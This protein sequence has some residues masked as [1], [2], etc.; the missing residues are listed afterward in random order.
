MRDP[1]ARKAREM[2]WEA[3]P[4]TRMTSAEWAAYPKDDF[5]LLIRRWCSKHN[6]IDYVEIGKPI[7][8]KLPYEK[9]NA[10]I[11]VAQDFLLMSEK[12]RAMQVFRG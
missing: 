8:A 3:M 1:T 11:L 4:K 10:D 5:A 6:F 12:H 7:P 9:H 2:Y